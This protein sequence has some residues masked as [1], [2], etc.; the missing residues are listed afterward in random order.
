MTS[1][2]PWHCGYQVI[3]DSPKILQEEDITESWFLGLVLVEIRLSLG[4]TLSHLSQTIQRRNFPWRNTFFFP[5]CCLHRH[6]IAWK[7]SILLSLYSKGPELLGKRKVNRTVYL[8]RSS[9]NSALE[10]IITCPCCHFSYNSLIPAWVKMQL[11]FA[12]TDLREHKVSVITIG[13]G[14]CVPVR[15]GG[16]RRKRGE[17]VSTGPYLQNNETEI[18][19]YLFSLQRLRPGGLKYFSVYWTQSFPAIILF[20]SLSLESRLCLQ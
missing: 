7:F 6:S 13:E 1:L 15:A 16:V 18:V 9:E 12:E 2:P 11:G 19:P 10:M 20:P 17:E 5:H 8:R 3:L 14:Q 4:D